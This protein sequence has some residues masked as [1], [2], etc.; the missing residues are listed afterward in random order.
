LG[1]V[2]SRNCCDCCTAHLLKG[3]TEGASNDMKTDEDKEV[4]MTEE[5]RN[6]VEA[7]E[8]L[9]DGK[10]LSVL[11][12]MLKGVKN[13]S[14]WDRHMREKVWGSGKTKTKQFWTA[15]V[16]NLVSKGILGEIKQS[17]Y[18]GPRNYSWSGLVVTPKGHKFLRG[19]ERM[20]LKA[21]GDLKQKVKVSVIAPKFGSDSTPGDQA[22]TK[23]Y[24][25]LVKVR[26]VI[27]QTTKL[28]PYMICTEQ[29]LLQMAQTR[30]TTK[31]NLSKVIGFNT[32]KLTNYGQQF[33]AA[34]VQFCVEENLET[35][36]F[37][38]I[39]PTSND[40]SEE[41]MALTDTLRTSYM[42]YKEGK[43]IE[44][45]AKERG[46]A[47]STVMSHL[48]TC[49]EKGLD[50]NL[51]CLGVTPEKVLAVAKAVWEPPI[52]SD[53]TRFGPIKE[54]LVKSG[55]E[56]IDWGILK[57]AVGRLKAEHGV[58]EEGLLKWNRED[59]QGYGGS[60]KPIV[61]RYVPAPFT[62]DKLGPSKL[63][64]S[65]AN[66]PAPVSTKR[67]RDNEPDNNETLEINRRI[68]DA[69]KENDLKSASSHLASS[70]KTKL[71]AFRAPESN[72]EGEH[73]ST[74]QPSTKKKLPEWMLSAEGKTEMAKKKMKTNSLFK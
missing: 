5:A 56:D 34:I 9:G 55:R 44:S 25:V 19:G 59:Y 22:R 60:V 72:L 61:D 66:L 70:F 73:V 74:H 47:A 23:L 8:V 29:T 4:D 71:A 42:M 13:K 2:R 64:S 26:L 14:I 46:I 40:M 15:L 62:G 3:G 38:Q 16:R 43:S 39:Q 53:V 30:P 37:P 48:G 51:G 69:Q 11:L 58:S 45:I 6:V 41:V 52:S 35:D 12:D 50:I 54:E 21:V 57:L 24:S 27:S 1:L 7:V 32:A 18:G 33:I 49:L 36:K 10:S 67:P 68:N 28:P 65:A 17:S 63:L 31:E 20:M